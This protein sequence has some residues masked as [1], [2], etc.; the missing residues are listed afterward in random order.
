MCATTFQ[1]PR[2]AGFVQD[3]CVTFINKTDPF[4]PTKCEDYGRKILKAFD[5]HG[6]N[7]EE[8]V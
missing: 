5:P 3:V 8:S 6:L 4:I 7:I 1:S 2:H